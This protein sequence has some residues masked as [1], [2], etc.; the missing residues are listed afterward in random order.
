MIEAVNSVLSNAPLVRN[1]T[2]QQSAARALAANPD[3]VQEV[4]QA[5]YISPYVHVDVNF[6][7]AVLQIRD[8]DTGDVVRTIPSE[9]QMEAYRRAQAA[10]A[11]ALNPRND[12]ADAPQVDV[13][14]AP[15][16]ARVEV[17][18]PS[19]TVSV[20]QAPAAPPVQTAA[21]SAPVSVDTQV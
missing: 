13:P 2:D 7:K 19:Q 20:S 14:D 4:A 15:A 9:G 18:V 21:I 5:P 11:P 8:S 6:D 3:R 1:V 17:N 16:Q 12:I 10:Q